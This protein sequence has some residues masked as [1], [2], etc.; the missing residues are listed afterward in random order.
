M[1]ASTKNVFLLSGGSPEFRFPQRRHRRGDHRLARAFVR[2]G[3]PGSARVAG[4]R[5]FTHGDATAQSE[6]WIAWSSLAATAGSST[7][8]YL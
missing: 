1:T 4:V 6:G 3:S 8:T 5:Q 2:S 7:A